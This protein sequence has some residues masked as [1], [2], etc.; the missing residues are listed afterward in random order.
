MGEGG[1]KLSEWGC[2]SAAC[3]GS[4]GA[5]AQ[6]AV[7]RAEAWGKDYGAMLGS[8]YED[9]PSQLT[10]RVVQHSSGDCWLQLLQADFF[11]VPAAAPCLQGY[12]VD[13]L[14]TSVAKI[15]STQAE[16]H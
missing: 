9:V 1:C 8:S 16:T 2:F 15:T 7:G 4:S 3:S 11:P 13:L 12:L 14:A 5:L 10:V 6:V